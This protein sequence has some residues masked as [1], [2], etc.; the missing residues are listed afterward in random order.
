MNEKKNP[1]LQQ[2]RKMNSTTEF[3]FNDGGF[4]IS[5]LST[6]V[7]FFISKEKKILHQKSVSL[8]ESVNLCI[9]F[10]WFY[11]EFCFIWFDHLFPTIWHDVFVVPCD[12][13]WKKNSFDAIVSVFSKFILCLFLSSSFNILFNY[14]QNLNKYILHI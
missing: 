1:T 14:I 9:S 13:H 12:H 3:S 4:L 2:Q 10:L 5:R 11:F 6:C 8:S 7:L